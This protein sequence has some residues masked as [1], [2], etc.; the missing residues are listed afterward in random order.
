MPLALGYRI[1]LAEAAEGDEVVGLAAYGDPVAARVLDELVGLGEPEGAAA[2][3]QPAVEDD[4][5]DLAAL[6]AA[7][8][9]AEHPALPELHGAA[10]A[11]LVAVAG[12]C[13]DLT[14]GAADAAGE[15]MVGTHAE[16]GRQ[17]LLVGLGGED[18]AFELG[19]R[20]GA[21][22]DEPDGQ[23]RPRGRPRGPYRGHGGRLDQSGRMGRGAVDEDGGGPPGVVG[24]VSGLV[25]VAGGRLGAVF[26]PR[27]LAPVAGQRAG[28]R[29]RGAARAAR[30]RDGDEG[31]GR[32]G[33]LGGSARRQPV[34]DRLEQVRGRGQRPIER[35][36]R[37]LRGRGLAGARLL[38]D[39]QPRGVGGPAA[40]VERAVDGGGQQDVGGGVGGG[41]RGAPVGVAGHA[42]GRGDRDEA[43]AGAQ[44][45][46]G[47]P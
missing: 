35:A 2:A 41:E 22:A 25:A 30:D 1:L 44:R 19:V 47:G 28:E 23:Q 39:G 8:A 7:G 33:R 24:T 20:E 18:D 26:Q 29:S 11:R 37:L 15:V 16:P 10:E 12:V 46:V 42:T 3:L 34:E 32:R 14:V 27:G 21:A 17:L 36:A 40:A 6:A 38:D 31:P 4:G 43:A 5:G 13:F 9:V 45:R